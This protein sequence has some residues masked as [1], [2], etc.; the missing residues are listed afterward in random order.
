MTLGY[1]ACAQLTVLIS[2]NVPPLVLQ[3]CFRTHYV[4]DAAFSNPP[5]SPLHRPIAGACLTFTVPGLPGI[6]HSVLLGLFL[7]QFQDG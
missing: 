7:D 1:P 6:Q 5:I 4:L 2:L 3:L